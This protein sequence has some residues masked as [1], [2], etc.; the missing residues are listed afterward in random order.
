[1]LKGVGLVENGF[2]NRRSH[3]RLL[4]DSGGKNSSH[5]QSAPGSPGWLMRRF[6][7]DKACAVLCR[8]FLV[9]MCLTAFL[10][11]YV[12]LRSEIVVFR[13]ELE[14][15][16]CDSRSFVDV[17]LKVNIFQ[18]IKT[19]WSFWFSVISEREEIQGKY[20][21]VTSQ[22]QNVISNQTQNSNHDTAA[23]QQL[24]QLVKQVGTLEHCFGLIVT[25]RNITIFQVQSINGTLSEVQS[26]LK[27]A[28]E[29]K[30]LPQEVDDIKNDLAK[31]GSKL[32]E[33]E[34]AVGK[35]KVK[36]LKAQLP[37]EG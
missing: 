1:M 31:F 7:A 10:A 25:E 5:S 14:K 11:L 17:F 19:F 20:Q 4:R 32:T 18:M 8:V 16:V 34:E 9:V 28:P 24:A 37:C 23:D 33:L 15:G 26:S 21:S 12:Q 2:R 30:T 22:L 27:A 29:L 13:K 36:T 3:R 6:A 35:A